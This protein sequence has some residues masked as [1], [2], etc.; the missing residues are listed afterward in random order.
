VSPLPVSYTERIISADLDRS[1]LKDF[2]DYFN[3]RLIALLYRSWRKYRAYANVAL[4]GGD[5]FTA[6]LFALGG[7]ADAEAQLPAPIDRMRLLPFVGLMR[8][9][10]KSAGTL[11]R[12]L[13][14]YFRDVDVRIEEL[15]Q[16]PVTVPDW[17]RN[18]LGKSGNLLGSDF[19]L[20]D[21]GSDVSGK[22][23][24]W[25][26]PLGQEQFQRFLPDGEEYAAMQA[27]MRLLLPTPLEVD[28]ALKLEDGAVPP[29]L[30]GGGESR[31]G[32]SS[33]AGEGNESDRTVVFG[34][35]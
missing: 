32:W 6:R 1:D 18:Q 17:Q 12:I 19:I 31:L 30:L 2:L 11:A 9:R 22:I 29:M 3:H 4:D 5:A 24:V 20:G 26:G 21:Q 13:Q 23:R 14:G 27:L 7:I 35:V 8:L 33:W 28:L 15:V 16:R 25:M 10:T 34:L